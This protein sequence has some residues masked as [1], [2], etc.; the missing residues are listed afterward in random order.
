VLILKQPLP[1]GYFCGRQ[2]LSTIDVTSQSQASWQR[3][4]LMLVENENTFFTEDTQLPQMI[5]KC[6][7]S[8]LVTHTANEKS[9]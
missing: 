6:I 4:D 3:M 7:S 9:R 8:H 5:S 1:A 2:H